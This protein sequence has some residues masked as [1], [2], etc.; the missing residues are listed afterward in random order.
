MFYVNHSCRRAELYW[1]TALFLLVTLKNDYCVVYP[2]DRLFELKSN[3]DLTQDE[4]AAY[5]E[6]GKLFIG[7]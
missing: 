5:I 6:K 4:I 3:K 1:K 2:K 7:K